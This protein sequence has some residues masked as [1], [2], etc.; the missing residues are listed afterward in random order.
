MSDSEQDTQPA[1]DDDQ[2]SIDELEQVSGG[3]GAGAASNTDEPPAGP[4]GSDP[5]LSGGEPPPP[6]SSQ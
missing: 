5:L 2:L 1:G 3:L 6:P 4:P